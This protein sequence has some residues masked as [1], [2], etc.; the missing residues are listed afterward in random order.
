MYNQMCPGCTSPTNLIEN[1]L[2]LLHR[3]NVP[4][5]I[6]P[7]H[8]IQPNSL[9]LSFSQVRIYT[10]DYIFRS[11][12]NMGIDMKVSMHEA[13]EAKNQTNVKTVLIVEDDE[14]IGEFLV[15]ALTSETLYEVLW[16]PDAVQALE[17]VKTIK[18]SLLL[19]DFHLPGLNGLELYDRLHDIP[20]LEHVRAVMMSA[21]APSAQEMRKRHIILVKKPFDL[22]D[23]LD[24][25]D[26]L[27][28]D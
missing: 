17:A 5:Q 15:R 26:E 6:P 13:S 12:P 25:L 7:H 8:K 24:L 16:V 23:L 4:F 9:K 19:L 11:L 1:S 3:D 14:N 21:S 27:L 10:R 20:E 28:R 22:N 18:P 2:P